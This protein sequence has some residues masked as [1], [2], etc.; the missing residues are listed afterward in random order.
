MFQLDTSGGC[1]FATD[2]F[3][4]LFC[5]PC[6]VLPLR[7][8][9]RLISVLAVGRLLASTA[10][11][12]A[13]DSQGQHFVQWAAKIFVLFLVFSITGCLVSLP[14]PTKWINTLGLS[15]P[16]LYRP[17]KICFPG[18]IRA[19]EHHWGAFSSK[20]HRVPLHVAFH[21]EEQFQR[22]AWVSAGSSPTETAW[23]R[24]ATEKGWEMIIP[25]RIRSCAWRLPVAISATQSFCYFWTVPSHLSCLYR[26][27]CI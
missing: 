11:R 26:C 5:N 8:R 16:Y 24:K 22:A 10:W 25:F 20:G 2:K 12:T 19:A 1:V 7:P 21:V 23:M 15:S 3:Q 27:S 6:E 9:C 13:L 18:L 4:G 17:C 14:A